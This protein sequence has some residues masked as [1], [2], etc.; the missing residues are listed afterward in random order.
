MKKKNLIIF[1]LRNSRPL[2]LVLLFAFFSCFTSTF[3]SIKNGGNLANII[4]QQAPFSIL[5][6]VSMTLVIILNGF[7]LSI[8]SAVALI[9][10]V[11]GMILHATYNPWL[12]I[13]AA[14]VMGCLA[15]LIN[16]FLV[17]KLG[18]SSFVAT[19]STQWIF[20]GI[21][22]VLLGGSQIFDLGPSF[23]PIFISH[24]WTFFIITVV[25][26]VVV[27]VLLS[28]T[29][30]GKQIYATG[31]NQTASKISG[32][33]TQKITILV[34]MI[35]GL[36]IGITSILYLANL[37][38]AEPTIG[39]DFALNAIAAT[40]I[41]GTLI[42]GGSG[43]V[44]NAVVG[45]LIMLFL[46]SGMIQSGVPSVWQQVIVGTVIVFSIVLERLIQKVP[47]ET[48]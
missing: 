44:Q 43:N 8:G 35:S 14:L 29:V 4:L 40:L 47:M 15:G 31:T 7:D 3:W 34:F 23:R 12:A 22:Y 46:S 11:C 36:I 21:A 38:T 16:G 37:G 19:Y 32:I 17:A 2:I 27:Q 18:I 25:I 1:F 6:A 30:F 13:A 48:E 28:C 26:L 42:G 41:G 45:A 20:Q 10:C 39:S 5:L 33:K 24:K 9:T